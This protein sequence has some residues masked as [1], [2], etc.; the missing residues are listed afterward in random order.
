VTPETRAFLAESLVVQ[1]ATVS[2]KGRP[3]MTPLWFVVD[4]DALYITTGPD[5]WAARNVAAHPV[6]TLLFGGERAGRRDR[7]LRLRGEATRHR[8]LPA[9]PVLL[10][11]A[12]KYYVAPAALAIELRH[13]ARWGLRARYYAQGGAGYLRVVPTTAELVPVPAP[14]GS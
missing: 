2:P 6:V 11:I 1:V 7:F 14:P 12:A 13:A 8:G 4:A 10:R 5:T 3:F 9:W